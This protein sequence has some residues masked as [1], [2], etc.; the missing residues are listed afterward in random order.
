MADNDDAFD[1]LV[2]ISM[3][4]ARARQEP[5]RNERNKHSRYLKRFHKGLS[6]SERR[7]RSCYIPRCALQRPLASAFVKLMRS[8]HDG[9]L[10]QATGLDFSTFFDLHNKFAPVYSKGTPYA[11]DGVIREKWSKGRHR[12]L[13]TIAGLGLVLMWTRSRGSNHLLSMVFG[14]TVNPL[15]LW[16]RFGTRRLLKI[17]KKDRDAKIVP[18]TQVLAEKIVDAI[19]TKYSDWVRHELRLP[20]MG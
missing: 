16:L 2:M 1:D 15:N 11:F 20:S 3:Y 13:N 7:R 17:L 5:N 10:I 9:A 19:K 12:N 18:P 14:S 4:Y 8:E 6:R